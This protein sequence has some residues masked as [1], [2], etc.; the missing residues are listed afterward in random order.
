MTDKHEYCVV[1]LYVVNALVQFIFNYKFE[2]SLRNFIFSL[3][4]HKY[5]GQS[6]TTPYS[7]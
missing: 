4:D 7:E 3:Y 2:L 1:L 5:S 6:I